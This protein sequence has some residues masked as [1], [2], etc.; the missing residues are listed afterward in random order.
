MGD[1]LLGAL[2]GANQSFESV[3][4]EPEG[5]QR[6]SDQASF[7]AADAP[8]AVH[9]SPQGLQAVVD[10][11]GGAPEVLR[12]D[13]GTAA[14]AWR[15]WFPEVTTHALRSSVW[16]RVDDAASSGSLRWRAGGSAEA[17]AAPIAH[18]A[19]LALYVAETQVVSEAGAP[20]AGLVRVAAAMAPATAYLDDVL[21]MVDGQLLH[22]EWSLEERA[23]LVRAQY[24]TQ[25]SLLHSY[26]WHLHAEFHVPLRWL[27]GQQA[28]LL[29]WW[30][31][32]QAPLAFTLD[33]SDAAALQ[34][35]RLVND[36]QPIGRRIR[37]YAD[38]WEGT[39]ELAGL[40]D[41]RLVF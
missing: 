33:S 23:Q 10:S 14:D 9:S 40:G 1:F 41:G 18:G 22:P 38:A 11:T 39:L 25:A 13:H 16:A 5:W 2:L 6:E 31:E 19:G 15:L 4:A 37:P 34:V 28:A 35:C 21:T 17:Y 26:T 20:H 24:R 8:T 32:Q 30:W 3:A 27:S 7:Y 36:S 29:N 12:Y